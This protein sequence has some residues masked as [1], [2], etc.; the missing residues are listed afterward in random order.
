MAIPKW[1]EK[2]AGL[3]K[4]CSDVWTDFTHLAAVISGGCEPNVTACPDHAADLDAAGADVL[5]SFIAVSTN[6]AV[7]YP[8]MH[9]LACH[10][11]DMVRHWGPLNQYSSLPSL[12]VATLVDKDLCK[13]QQQ[14]ATGP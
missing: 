12:R 2:D 6:E 9:A 10:L 14:E 5:K 3:Y 7:R 1:E 4:R 11:G 13:A 8:Y